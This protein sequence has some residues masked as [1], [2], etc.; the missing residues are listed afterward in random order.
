MSFIIELATKLC[1]PLYILVAPDLLNLAGLIEL[2]SLDA[3]EA[4]FL[5]G[6]SD[7]L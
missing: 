4:L 6:I 2:P 5:D 7:V 1:L 3:R